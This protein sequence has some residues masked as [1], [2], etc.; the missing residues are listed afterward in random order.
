MIDPIHSLPNFLFL[1]VKV[2]FLKNTN[3]FFPGDKQFF[4]VYC[5]HLEYAAPA[6]SPH[7]SKDITIIE[8]EQSARN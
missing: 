8:K 6:W 4:S 7:L 1:K 2:V 5:P 3:I